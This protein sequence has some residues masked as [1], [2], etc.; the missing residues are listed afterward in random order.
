MSEQEKEDGVEASSWL[1]D[2]AKAK[3][4]AVN[5]VIAPVISQIGSGLV[6]GMQIAAIQ[7]ILCHLDKETLSLIIIA[8][9]N[10]LAKK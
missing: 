7:K 10:E 9:Q 4:P 1:S 3:V 6:N 5:P 8:A 2:I